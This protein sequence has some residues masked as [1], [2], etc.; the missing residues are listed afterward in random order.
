MPEITIEATAPS[1]QAVVAPRLLAVLSGYAARTDVT[2]TLDLGIADAAMSVPV[3]VSLGDAGTW[4]PTVVPLALRATQRAGWFPTFHGEISSEAGG[5]LESTLRMSGTYEAPLG[6]LGAIADRTVLAHAAEKSLRSFL[7][8]L[9][10]DVLEE[11]RR[12]ELDLRRYD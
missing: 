7:A 3:T 10:T 1:P 8:R 12:S 5:P 2:L 4:T 6:K 9:R 11:I